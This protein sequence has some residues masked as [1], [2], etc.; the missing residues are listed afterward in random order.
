MAEEPSL[1]GPD[2]GRGEEDGD[3]L[4]PAPGEGA[5]LAARM[6]PRTLEEFVGQEEVVGEGG[7]L[8]ELIAHDRV[9]SLIFWGPLVQ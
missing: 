3:P 6:R 4:G 2:A 8:R 5:P 9:P 1:F 7:P